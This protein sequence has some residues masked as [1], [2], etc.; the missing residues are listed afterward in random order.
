MFSGMFLAAEV[1][2]REL[3]PKARRSRKEA[4]GPEAKE[5]R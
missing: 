1:L 5:V 3:N 4:V 2:A